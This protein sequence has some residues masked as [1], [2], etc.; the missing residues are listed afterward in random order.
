ME[1]LEIKAGIWMYM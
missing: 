1:D